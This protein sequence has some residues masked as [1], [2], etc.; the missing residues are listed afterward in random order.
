MAN[1][2]FSREN[3]GGGHM[4]IEQLQYLVEVAE[5]GSINLAAENNYVSHQGLSE[6]IR[7][8]EKEFGTDLLK[9]S[10]KGIHLT[11]EGKLF[12]E[13]AKV[14]LNDIEELK[15]E[16]PYNKDIK[17]SPL[18]GTLKIII[19]P[20]INNNLLQSALAIFNKDHPRVNIVLAENDFLN[21]I[22]QVADNR[23]DIGILVTTEKLLAGDT[24]CPT[25]YDTDVIF[26]KLHSD[27]L[28]MCAGKMSP[29]ANRKSISFKEAIK[30]PIIV[31][32]P[33]EASD[34]S[35][36]INR[37]KTTGDIDHFIVTSSSD[38]YRKTIVKGRAIGYSAL[39]Y[40]DANPSFKN[41]ITVL[42]IKGSS[43]LTCGWI[44]PKNRELSEAAKE[45]IK[46]WHRNEPNKI[47]NVYNKG[48][49]KASGSR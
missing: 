31:Y 9:R 3:S 18:K 41:E 26:E 43:K 2:N 25:N 8:L 19:S 28:V 27:K 39:S 11:A 47:N 16:F 45:F 7:K 34:N 1:M 13:K 36:Y 35:W 17:V 22:S 40:L 42:S 46:V 4:R 20:L 23:A 48:T 44:R 33:D 49:R 5:T 29:L 37:L 15:K 14:I 32:Q 12:V 21:V 10:C 24:Q 38:V 6:A 30:Y